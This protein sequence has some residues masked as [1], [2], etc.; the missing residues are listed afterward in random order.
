MVQRWFVTSTGTDIGKTLV[1]AALAHQFREAGRS[2]SVLKPVLSG[3]DRTEAEHSDSGILLRACGLDV[4]DGH[5]DAITPWRFREPLS[6]DMAA[7][8]EGRSLDCTEIVD[9]CR[10]AG[11]RDV[12]VCLVEGVGGAMVPIDA[13]ST[14]L[15]WIA[16]LGW[17]TLLVAGSY[18]GTIS[19]TLTA[20]ETMH[21]RGVAPAVV[22]LSESEISPVPLE[23]T[24]EAI[25]RYLPA[26]VRVG[27]VPRVATGEPEPW[28]QVPPLLT[29]LGGS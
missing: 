16:A 20:Y 26:S 14:V 15:D 9:F 10:A 4:D 1:S 11:E 22:L 8:R 18:L 27:S 25:A 23:E 3:F 7:A 6:P 12:E 19:H 24:A 17:P 28:R 29:L 5:L 21:T 13:G 2:V